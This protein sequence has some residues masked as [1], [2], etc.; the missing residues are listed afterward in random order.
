MN[1]DHLDVSGDGASTRELLGRIT[2]DVRT[3]AR[4]ELELLRGEVKRVAKTVAAEAA[5]AMFGG[6]VAL[7]GF[8][9]LCVAAVVALAPLVPSL[10]L[11]LVLMAV[12]YGGIGGVLAATFGLR[13]RRDV[14]PDL[15][16]PI[17]EAASTVKGV[18]ATLQERG[19]QVHA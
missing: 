9:M 1:R 17:H 14:V 12:V 11:R 19:R 3:I 4:D 6:V 15:K 16:V 18:K 10:A 13:I 7:I 5:V 2:E 8:A